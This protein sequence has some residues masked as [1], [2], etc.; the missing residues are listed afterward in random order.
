VRLL[1][2]PQPAALSERTRPVS[3]IA[4]ERPIT[5]DREPPSP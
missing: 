5:R 2:S 3:K 4:R 1:S